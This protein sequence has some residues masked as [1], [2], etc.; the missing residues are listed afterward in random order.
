[1]TLREFHEY[2]AQS[3]GPPHTIAA[4][5]GVAQATISDWLSGRNQPKAS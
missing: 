4:R 3:Y 5:I 2:F 1:M